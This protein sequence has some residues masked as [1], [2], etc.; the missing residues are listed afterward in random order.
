MSVPGATRCSDCCAARTTSRGLK[1]GEPWRGGRGTR[2]PPPPAKLLTTWKPRGVDDM[3]AALAW[4]V[5]TVRTDFAFERLGPWSSNQQGRRPTKP[6]K[7]RV[8]QG[9]VMA[10]AT[11]LQPMCNLDA[12]L[13]LRGRG[14]RWSPWGRGASE[15]RGPRRICVLCHLAP[16]VTVVSLAVQREPSC[17]QVA[18]LGG[19][20]FHGTSMELPCNLSATCLQL[21]C[22]LD[23]TLLDLIKL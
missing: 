2:C 19:H 8:P 18:F 11:W 1:R 16:G 22:N 10:G 4:T 15:H 20:K 5:R 17:I 6:H 13:R 14:R 7:K 3:A 12:R 23:A 9:K 21:G